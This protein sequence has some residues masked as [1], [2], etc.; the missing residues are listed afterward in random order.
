MLRTEERGSFIVFEF[1]KFKTISSRIFPVYVALT[2]TLCI[3]LNVRRYILLTEV[4]DKKCSSHQEMDG[5]M[6]M[7]A[8]R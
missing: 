7:L 2:L 3:Y 1:K 5:K 8:G 4:A 6:I